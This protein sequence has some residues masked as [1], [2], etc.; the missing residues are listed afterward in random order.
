MGTN[1]ESAT[2]VH[3]IFKIYWMHFFLRIFDDYKQSSTILH[4]Q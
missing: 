4:I 1:N 3:A 2:I